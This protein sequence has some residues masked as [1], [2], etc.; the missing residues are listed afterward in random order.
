MKKFQGII[1]ILLAVLMVMSVAS[2]GIFKGPTQTT[3]TSQNPAETTEKPEE[4]TNSGT[5]VDPE[6]TKTYNVIFALATIP[7]VLSALEAIQNGYPTYVIIERGKTYSG[8][9]SLE[10]F[11]NVGFDPNNNLSQGFTVKEFEDMVAQV[12]ALREAEEDIFI[13]FYVQ[14]GTAL[15]GAAIA[16]NAGLTTDQFHVYMCEDGTGAYAALYNTY[17]KN[18]T[19]SA[20]N[21]GIYD[22]YA[23][24]VAAAKAEF[25]TIMSKTDNARTDAALNYNIGKAFA[26]AALDNF[27]FYI[28]DEAQIVN[29]LKNASEIKSKLLTSFGVEGYEGEAELTLNLKYGKISAAVA[30]LTEEQRTDYLTLMYGQFY[31]DTY[32]ALTRT[33]RAD[34]AA[35]AKKLVYIGARHSGYPALVS[36]ASYG[37]GG[38]FAG[39]TV[40]ATYAELDAKYKTA[41]IFGTEADYQLFLD[42]L[43]NAENYTAD[44]PAEVKAAVGVACFNYYVDYIFNLKLT[45]AL[46]GEEYDIIMKGHPREVIGSWSEWGNRYKVTYGENKEQSYVYDKLYDNALLAFH[47]SD[48]VG[49]YIGMVPYGTAAENLAYLGADIVI[50]GLPSSTY[51]GFDTS[52]G[53][54]F[55]AALT[56]EDIVGTGK[57]TATSQVKERYEAGTL[58]YTDANGET[59]TTVFYNT[60]NLYKTIAEIYTELGDTANAAKYQ[61]QFDAWM[62]ANYPNADTIDGQ[63]FPVENNQ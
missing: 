46:Y 31:A 56:N 54:L 26:L 5:I 27:T 1:S 48:S 4:S 13:N 36:N 18:F 17:L 7:P 34:K 37:I 35:P 53:V 20:S 25:E 44:I 58:V 11:I 39:S 6:T 3:G 22:N 43:N 59:K 49:K 60:G 61:A 47:N 2:C 16:A 29:L 62:T 52:V 15:F 51:N 9:D 19:V 30:A 40:P 23:A 50:A 63:G 8:I 38:L 41:L 21:D 12:K 28:Q 24:K 33:T 10:N 32:A 55:I 14:D 57:D 45:Y 42:Q